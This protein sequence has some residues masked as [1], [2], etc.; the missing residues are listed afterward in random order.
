MQTRIIAHR[1]ASADA[2]E[3]TMPAFELAER[4]GAQML[5]FDVRPTADDAIVVFHD[6]TT[7]RW[8]GRP[9]PIAA[10][11]LEEVQQLDIRGATVPTLRE[12]L[13]WARATNLELNVEIKTPGIERQ[14][15]EL[16]REHGL[17]ER[18]I[19]SSFHEQVLV[20][21]HAVAP[22]LP[23]GVLMGTNSWPAT[24]ELPEQWPVPILQHL[25]ARAWHPTWQLPQLDQLIPQVRRAGIA[26]NVWT[27]D[28]PDMMRQLLALQVDGIITNRPAALRDIQAT[29]SAE[30]PK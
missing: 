12:L 4:Q 18:V 14:V 1:G 2:P 26:I 27:V 5:E 13:A 21:M 28:D 19:V 23:L 11:P 25:Q 8:N 24:P 16:V 20:A 17:V 9:Q 7:E 15:A 30:P 6:D 29:W 3:N 10:M 22:E